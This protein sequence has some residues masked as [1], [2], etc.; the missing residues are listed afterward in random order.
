MNY[1]MILQTLW[2]EKRE[3]LSYDRSPEVIWTVRGIDICLK[4]VKELAKEKLERNLSFYPRLET[5]FYS[6]LYR[7]G[8]SALR[9]MRY[10]QYAEARHTLETALR[11]IHKQSKFH[12]IDQAA[13]KESV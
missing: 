10:N 12:D 9:Q 6:R 1:R 3:W 11:S 8:I 13:A 5:Q 7:A 2:K 4:H